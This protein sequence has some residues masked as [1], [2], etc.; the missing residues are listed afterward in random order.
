[1]EVIY[2]TERAS[3][4]QVEMKST[5]GGTRERGALNDTTRDTMQKGEDEK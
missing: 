3:G 5:P 4:R 2:D 1:M